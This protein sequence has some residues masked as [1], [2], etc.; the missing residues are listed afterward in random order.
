MDKNGWGGRREGAGRP[1]GT[2]KKM[3]SLRLT[4]A[5][6]D[7]VR[8]YIKKRRANMELLELQRITGGQESG[9]VIYENNN[10]LLCNWTQCKGGEAPMVSPWGD[11]MPWQCGITQVLSEEEG[12]VLGE[13][14]EGLDFVYVEP[15]AEESGIDPNTKCRKMVLGDKDGE[16]VLTILV[17]EGWC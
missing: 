17:P 11:I 9:I 7:S 6:Y 10:A 2:D 16:E 12:L 5:E 1:K 3:R 4:D 8:Q 15:N 14:M 13:E